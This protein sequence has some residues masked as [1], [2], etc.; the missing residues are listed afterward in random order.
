MVV[1]GHVAACVNG[2]VVAMMKRAA[3]DGLAWVKSA[4]F[5]LRRRVPGE[6]TE[7]FYWWLVAAKR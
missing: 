3:P 1:M 4:F 2:V 5:T 6:P 7:K